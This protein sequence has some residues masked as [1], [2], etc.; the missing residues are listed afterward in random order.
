MALAQTS[1]TALNSSSENRQPRLV[2]GL[3][4]QVLSLAAEAQFI[5]LRTA[6]HC[7]STRLSHAARYMLAQESFHT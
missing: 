7:L 4:G 2:P 5:L 6:L 3:L 1:S